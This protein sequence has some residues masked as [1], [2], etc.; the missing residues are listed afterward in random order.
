MRALP[1]FLAL[2]TSAAS[3]QPPS[4]LAPGVHAAFLQEGTVLLLTHEGLPEH[5]PTRVSAGYYLSLT[6]HERLAGA[7]AQCQADAQA[8]RARAE[9][10]QVGM[11]MAPPRNP[12]ALSAG[13]AVLIG[14]LVLAAGA[15]GYSLG[16]GSPP[17]AE[18]ERAR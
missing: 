2:A 3:A 11:T 18:T 9:A 6:G 15:A 7:M 4:E 8:E 5:A 14:V 12:D 10:L 13:A 16:R 1:L 17:Q